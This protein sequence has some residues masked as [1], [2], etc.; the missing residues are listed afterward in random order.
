MSQLSVSNVH[1]VHKKE[2][3]NHLHMTN[4][5]SLG[6]EKK[7]RRKKK[8]FP[9]LPSTLLLP[10]RANQIQQ[11]VL[12]LLQLRLLL[13]Q[14]LCSRRIG[15]GLL[16]RFRLLSRYDVCL[17]DAI[18]SSS[19]VKASAELG[20]ERS[21]SA[22]LVLLDGQQLLARRVP[23]QRVARVARRAVHGHGRGGAVQEGA[24]VGERDELR[25]CV[26]PLGAAEE[27]CV[28]ALVAD[29]CC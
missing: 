17:F 24:A 5:S 11:I 4:I 2:G 29:V 16:G 27:G 23:E 15:L 1:V 13:S 3:E 21:Q 28:A 26:G 22:R 20:S 9:L 12:L 7:R 25:E 8:S 10:K 14:S 18:D 19:S 6:K